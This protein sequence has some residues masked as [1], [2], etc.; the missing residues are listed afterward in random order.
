M[1]TWIREN[2]KWEEE[3]RRSIDDVK[4]MLD[5]EHKRTGEKQLNIKKES[6]YR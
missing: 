5:E 6:Q 3:N 4:I 1:M 2:Y